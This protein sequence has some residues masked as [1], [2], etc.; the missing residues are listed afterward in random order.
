MGEPFVVASRESYLP[1]GPVPLV[2]LRVYTRA[3]KRTRESR[4]WFPWEWRALFIHDVRG[5]VFS[6]LLYP[7]CSLFVAPPFLLRFS[8]IPSANTISLWFLRSF[9][10]Y[11][12]QKRWTWK[13]RFSKF[14]DR[15]RSPLSCNQA[16]P[17]FSTLLQLRFR[18]LQSRSVFFSLSA[19][20]FIWTTVSFTF[21]N[22]PS[23]I[24]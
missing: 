1:L 16:S 8:T 21:L 13:N 15:V 22:N 6:V 20:T 12:R 4:G 7:E 19:Q 3:A 11:A 14:C 9:S 2:R 23:Y 24:Q 5:D 10:F 17:D 18:F